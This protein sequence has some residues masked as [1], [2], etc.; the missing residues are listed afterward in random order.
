M[1]AADSIFKL[2]K[3]VSLAKKGS[4][5]VLKA[6]SEWVIHYL[7]S[8][9]GNPPEVVVEAVR[10]AIKRL[11]DVLE[12]VE[13]AAA[14]DPLPKSPGKPT[15]A[16]QV[17]KNKEGFAIPLRA[18]IAAALAKASDSLKPTVLSS[19][20]LAQELGIVPNAVGPSS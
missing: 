4:E 8:R 9:Q 19:N 18:R 1:D 7:R 10:M 15:F 3:G 11:T 14:P 17:A 6:D 13:R 20:E 5:K 2:T 12:I 16:S